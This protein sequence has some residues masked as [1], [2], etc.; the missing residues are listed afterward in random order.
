[1]NEKNVVDFDKIEQQTV[2]CEVLDDSLVDEQFADLPDPTETFVAEQTAEEPVDMEPS[3]ELCELEQCSCGDELDAMLAK[4]EPID[5]SLQPMTKKDE[6]KIYMLRSIEQIIQTATNTNASFV[7]HAG[8][9]YYYTGAHYKPLTELGLKNFLTK[10]CLRCE[11]PPDT[12]RYHTFVDKV[13]KQFMS[14]TSLHN[15]GVSEPETAY[16]NLRNGTLF[17]GKGR[18]HLENH[19]HKRF[20]RYCLDFEY[21]ENASA[22]LWEQHLDRSLPNREKQ[23]F[24][25]KCLALVFYHGK[26][27]KAP[28]L[29]GERDTGKSTT[30][31]VIEALLT[32][33]EI[34]D[35]A[36]EISIL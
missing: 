23:D 36:S 12:A 27:E 14:D 25:A 26:I 13:V 7:N 3:T 10:A 31:D 20:I 16:I 28:A 9:V 35:H 30:L 8:I 22:P 19:S 32:F 1:M 15:S 2:D 5:W 29:Y 21:D 4:I 24:L 11:V 18:P 17:F 34:L 6:E 33:S